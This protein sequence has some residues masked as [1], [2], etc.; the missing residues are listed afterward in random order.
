MYMAGNTRGTSTWIMVPSGLPGVAV[1]IL[2]MMTCPRSFAIASS[3]NACDINDY[4]DCIGGCMEIL[5]CVYGW[6]QAWGDHMDHGTIMCS[7]SSSW[8]SWHADMP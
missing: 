2:G 1:G 3:M 8:F 7:W 6:E 4:L 5:P